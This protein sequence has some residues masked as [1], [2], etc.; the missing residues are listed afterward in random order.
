MEKVV[1]AR[2]MKNPMTGGILYSENLPI[3]F[4]SY[5]AELKYDP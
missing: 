4:S 3:F 2:L 1:P 5:L